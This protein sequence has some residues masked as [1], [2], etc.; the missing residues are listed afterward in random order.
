[1]ALKKMAGQKGKRVV[2]RDGA[3]RDNDESRK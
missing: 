1:M 3:D 2:S